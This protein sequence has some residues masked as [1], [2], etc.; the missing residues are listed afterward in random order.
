MQNLFT[1]FFTS[2]FSEAT[3]FKDSPKIKIVAPFH[4]PHCGF[5]WDTVK[6]FIEH[7]DACITDLANLTKAANKS[8]IAKYPDSKS[9]KTSLV[10]HGRCDRKMQTGKRKG[11]YCLRKAIHILNKEVCKIHTSRRM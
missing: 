3:S 11:Q 10:P 5:I 4:C 7:Q 9:S 1:E 2:L 8:Q 6:A